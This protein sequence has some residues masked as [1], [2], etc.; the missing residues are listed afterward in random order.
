[1]ILTF[2]LSVRTPNSFKLILFNLSIFADILSSLISSGVFTLS[3]VIISNTNSDA[4]IVGYM[5]VSGPQY[6]CLLALRHLQS[7]SSSNYGQSNAA[8]LKVNANCAVHTT[9]VKWN[10][11]R[12]F[13]LENMGIILIVISLYYNWPSTCIQWLCIFQLNLYT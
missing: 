6:N 10:R 8:W 13:H 5:L 12:S 3:R 1:V 2:S 11:I 4:C 7:P 9:T